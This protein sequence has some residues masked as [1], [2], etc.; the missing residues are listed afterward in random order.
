MLSRTIISIDL[1][2]TKCS[3]VYFPVYSRVKWS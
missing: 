2:F 3:S 1:E